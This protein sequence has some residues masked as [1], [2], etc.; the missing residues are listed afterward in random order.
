MKHEQNQRV[1]ACS[2][3]MQTGEKSPMQG[4]ALCSLPSTQR[5]SF[6]QEIGRVQL[7]ILLFTK[8]ICEFHLLL[9]YPKLLWKVWIGI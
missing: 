2:R 7:Q 4:R 1:R 9:I 3:Y 5:A 8:Q 6:I